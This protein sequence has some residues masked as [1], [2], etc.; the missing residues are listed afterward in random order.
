MNDILFNLPWVEF[1]LQMWLKSEISG[2]SSDIRA[3]AKNLGVI[4]KDEI[5]WHVDNEWFRN[6]LASDDEIS[7]LDS[8]EDFALL[9]LGISELMSR[10][11]PYMTH[12]VI[13]YITKAPAV[14][15][16]HDCLLIIDDNVKMYLQHPSNFSLETQGELQFVND[17]E[18][19]PECF[20]AV[21]RLL[22]NGSRHIIQSHSYGLYGALTLLLKI[23]ASAVGV[24]LEVQNHPLILDAVLYALK[25][26]YMMIPSAG[27]EQEIAQ[28][29]RSKHK[30]ISMTGL[31]PHQ[32]SYYSKNILQNEG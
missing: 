3:R 10:T 23:D 28:L 27:Y 13:Q 14:D 8:P 18:I 7:S 24:W 19:T 22:G 26:A 20:K 29:V 11:A 9:V 21:N 31:V 1:I 2:D 16:I 12:D 32:V 17:V 15:K 5:Y 6:K 25:Y 4:T 30:L